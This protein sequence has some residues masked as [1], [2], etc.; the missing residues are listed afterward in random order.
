MQLNV[1]ES[2]ASAFEH[3]VRLRLLNGTAQMDLCGRCLD[4]F[5]RRRAPRDD[6]DALHILLID[7]E[8]RG[9]ETWCD[10]RGVYNLPPRG[11][12]FSRRSAPATVARTP[13][14]GLQEAVAR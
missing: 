2:C 10:P 13:L 9:L 4:R 11:D 14:R 3:V 7:A 1:C 5:T 8:L 6:V 12:M